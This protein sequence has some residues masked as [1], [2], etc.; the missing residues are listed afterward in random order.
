MIRS[1]GD[2]ATESIFNGIDSKMSRRLSK[3]LWP[4]IRRVLDQ[5][6]AVRSVKEMAIP[7]AN[8]LERLKGDL[9]G[10]FSVRVSDQ[11]RVHFRFE[12]G[13]AWEVTCENYH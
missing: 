2:A 9:A 4:R 6:N 12:D 3:Q 5:L 11:F 13:D 8:S 1:F 10:R 7:P